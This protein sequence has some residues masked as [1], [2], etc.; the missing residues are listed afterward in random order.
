MRIQNFCVTQ[1]SITIKKEKY[2][3]AIVASPTIFK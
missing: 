2:Y 1:N 3:N